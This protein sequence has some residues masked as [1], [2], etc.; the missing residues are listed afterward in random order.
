ME[1]KKILL[2]IAIALSFAFFVGYGIETFDPTPNYDEV[3]PRLWELTS[4]E[5]CEKN[6]GIWQKPIADPVPKPGTCME[7]QDCYLNFQKVESK[8]DKVVFLISLAVGIIAVILGIILKIE[9]ISIGILAGGIICL[10]YGTIRY[11]QYANNLLKFILL[12]ITLA[13]LI[14]IGFKIK[15]RK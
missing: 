2:I 9:S 11:W 10:L 13:I 5:E 12:G 4:Q 8:H 3:C 1:A 6:Q 14:V 15:D 7:K